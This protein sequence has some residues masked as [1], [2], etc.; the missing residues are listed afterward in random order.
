V[1]V[2]TSSNTLLGT[3]TGRIKISDFSEFPAK[4]RG[5]SGVRAQSLLKGEDALAV[6]WAGSGAPIA[7]GLDGSPRDLPT[8]RTK[9]DASGEKLVDDITFIGTSLG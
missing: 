7:N 4:G 6:A 2:S 3:D 9:R 5:T 8:E 1:T